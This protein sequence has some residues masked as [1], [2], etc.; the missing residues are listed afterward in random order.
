[1]YDFAIVVKTSSEMLGFFQFVGQ[2]YCEL[3]ITQLRINDSLTTKL[4]YF[5]VL[6]LASSIYFDEAFL[7]MEFN[8]A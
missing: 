8:Y 5:P 2:R 3:M 1:M 7:F 6:F 4:S